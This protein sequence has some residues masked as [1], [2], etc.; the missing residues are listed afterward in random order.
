MGFP[1]L[2]TVG[3]IKNIVLTC[4]KFYKN[5]VLLRSSKTLNINEF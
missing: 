1:F 3:F 5:F 4:Y 2:F